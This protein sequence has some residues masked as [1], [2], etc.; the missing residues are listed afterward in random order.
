MFDQFFS[1]LGGDCDAAYLQ[2]C[3]AWVATAKALL[4]E[5]EAYKKSHIGMPPAG[6]SILET[7]IVEVENRLE[8]I[9]SAIAKD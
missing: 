5:V 2:C 7:R 9:S 6:V 3:E 1:P 4:P 8:E